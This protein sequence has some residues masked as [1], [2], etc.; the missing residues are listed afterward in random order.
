MRHDERL[1]IRPCGWILRVEYHLSPP[2]GLRFLNGFAVGMAAFGGG[3]SKAGPGRTNG[4]WISVA[5]SYS[6][7][8]NG[9][10]CPPEGMP[11]YSRLNTSSPKAIRS[12]SK[13][14]GENAS[15]SPAVASSR[16]HACS[17]SAQ[18]VQNGS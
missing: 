15:I 8:P 12:F 4:V 18:A 9:L 6:S 3:G 1:E 11:R 16:I 14:S 13:N 10:T 7:Q 5:R 17:S 2:I